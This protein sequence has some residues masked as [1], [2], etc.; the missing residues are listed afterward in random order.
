VSRR[1]IDIFRQEVQTVKDVRGLV[2]FL[3]VYPIPTNAVKA[4]KERGGNALGIDEDSPLISKISQMPVAIRSNCFS[5][6]MLSLIWS[7]ASDD[8]KMSAFSNKVIQE[9][10]SVAVSENADH[11]YIYINYAK[12]DQDPF[13]SYE[14]QNR[15]RLT[16][17][18]SS[19][20][21]HG[22]FTSR[23]LWRGFFK[24]Q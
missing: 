20:D 15:K 1:A 6:T 16:E 9:I 14:E 11:P 7:D 23:G 24:L 21:P 12:Y 4:M 8:A 19:V 2:P 3:I 22:I 5:V 13:T 17:I 10:K 18:Q